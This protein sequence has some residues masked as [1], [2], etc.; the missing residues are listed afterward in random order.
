MYRHCAITAP[1]PHH[2]CTITAPSLNH[3]R[4]IPFL[5]SSIMVIISGI[6]RYAG[7]GWCLEGLTA[8]CS[9]DKH[10]EQIQSWDVD[11]SWD[12]RR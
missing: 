8:H 5:S 3:H 7:N 4:A 9:G 11:T 12:D 1:S 10:P 6:V 2:H